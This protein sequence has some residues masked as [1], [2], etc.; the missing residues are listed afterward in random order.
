MAIQ[1]A[2]RKAL[3]KPASYRVTSPSFTVG[4]SLRWSPAELKKHATEVLS[5]SPDV[6][7][8]FETLYAACKGGIEDAIKAALGG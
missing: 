1:A 4:H 2:V 7:A 5:S 3:H 6:K 8:A